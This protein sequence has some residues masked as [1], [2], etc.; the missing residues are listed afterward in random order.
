MT[1]FGQGSRARRPEVAAVLSSA[2]RRC[3]SD[4]GADR[5]DKGAQRGRG[6]G[7]RALEGKQPTPKPGGT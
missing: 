1:G 2:G 3:V 6:S 5:V 4:R 7:G